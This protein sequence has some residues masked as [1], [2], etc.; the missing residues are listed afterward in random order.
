LVLP[1]H[2]T[3]VSKLPADK[4]DVVL[5]A[6]QRIAVAPGDYAVPHA[7]S[8]AGMRDPAFIAK[9]TRGPAGVYDARAG[10]A[11]TMGPYLALWF[12]YCLVVSACTALLVWQIVGP[13]GDPRFAFHYGGLIGLLAY[14][15]AFAATLDLGTGGAGD[16]VQV[17]VRQPDLRLV[18]GG[19]F[20]WYG[21]NSGQRAV[22]SGQWAWGSGQW[23][24]RTRRTRRNS[25]AIAA[26]KFVDS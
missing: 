10:A 9:A 13:G 24:V 8:S 15:M 25:L 16:H 2:R 4:E 21:R 1:Y 17:V 26:R 19:I 7:G 6:L 22:G 23:A 14:G 11:P 5:D 12:V 18:T 20:A 3:D